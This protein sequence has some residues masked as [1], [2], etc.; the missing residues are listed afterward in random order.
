MMLNMVISALFLI[1]VA[2]AAG[3]IVIASQLR[4]KYRYE[5]FSTLLFMQVFYFM[6]GFYALWGQVIIIS[7]VTPLVSEATLSRIN[8]IAVLL[9]SPFIIFGWLMMLKLINEIAGRKLWRIF[10]TVFLSLNMA[11]LIVTGI[12]ISNSVNLKVLDVLKY[13]FIFSNFFHSVIVAFWLLTCRN[14]QLMLKPEAMKNLGWG[15]LIFMLAQNGLLVFY[16]SNLFPAL[17]FIFL[18]F[19]GT[20]FVTV[21]LK[22]NIEVKEQMHPNVL[23][24]FSFDE[25][26]KKYEISPRERDIIE[27]ICNGL[28]NQQIADKLFISLQ[29]V[30]DHTHRIY[31]KTMTTSRMQLMKM[32]QQLS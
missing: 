4:S 10:N 16:D 8:E 15:I 32:V 29:T 31:G 13:Y 19:A 7:Y 3:S 9:G 12:L 30:K 27:E 5:T 11:F 1:S 26:C 22:Y 25:F 17:I 2:I 28:S 24:V 23:P 20:A 18:F 6:F 21:F 14:K